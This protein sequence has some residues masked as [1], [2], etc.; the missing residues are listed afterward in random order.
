MAKGGVTAFIDKYNALSV[1]DQTVLQALSALYEP[2]A[3]VVVSSCL[4]GAGCRES[5]MRAFSPQIVSV[6]LAR[7]G[8]AGFAVESTVE[9]RG[10][11]VR[12]W[13]CRP[14]I[15][16]IAIR[17]AVRDG[18]F[19]PMAKAV[20]VETRGRDW[21]LEGSDDSHARRFRL[22]FH[23]GD[24]RSA[25]SELVAL[26]EEKPGEG[27]SLLASLVRLQADDSWRRT[28]KPALFA[29]VLAAALND[30]FNGA[31]DSEP[32]DSLAAEILAAGVDGAAA[33]QLTLA[34]VDCLVTRGRLRDA[35]RVAQQSSADEFRF[36]ALL[37]PALAEG[38]EDVPAIAESAAA[39]RRA[40]QSARDALPRGTAAVW[41]ALA[42]LVD[43]TPDAVESML[44]RLSGPS[45]REH[46]YAGAL[47]CLRHAFLFLAGQAF[48]A[49]NIPDQPPDAMPL[50]SLV[51]GL[52][53]L[54]IDPARLPALAEH[55]E[56]LEK[57]SRSAGYKWLAEQFK[58][59]GA[60]AAGDRVEDG[61]DDAA[62]WLPL[63]RL[64]QGDDEWRRGL[65]ALDDLAL[66]D[67]IEGSQP[68]KRLAWLV[69]AL[70]NPDNPYAPFEIQPIEQSMGKDGAWSKGRN[71]ALRRIFQHADDLSYV[72]DQDRMIFST[73]R[74][75]YTGQGFRFDSSAALPHL[76]GHPLV[77]RGDAG[78]ARLDVVAGEFEL[79][80]AEKDGGCEIGMEPSL[81]DFLARPDDAA[82]R[83]TSE[84]ELPDTAARLETP[85]RLRVLRLGARERRLARV[86]G[87]GLAIPSRGRSEAV[88][89]LSRLSG[90]IRLHSDIPELAGEGEQVEADP[91]P[92]FHVTPQNPGLK[93]EIWAHPLGDDGP[94]YRPGKGGRVL[95]ADLDGRTVRTT[96][97]IRRE[98]ELAEEALAACPSLSG[99][100]D[101]DLSWRLDDPEDALA[102]LAETE[103]LGDKAVL[104]WPKGGRF[105]VRR[106]KGLGGLS[107]RVNSSSEWFELDGTL[108]VDENLVLDMGRLM[109]SL[110]ASRGRFVEIGDGEY[111][112]LT[113][114]LRRQLG[115][116][117]AMGEFHD[118]K[119]RLHSLAGSVLEGLEEAG[120]EL[121]DDAEWRRTLE[122]RKKLA[123][124]IPEPPAG[125]TAE[126]RDY[127]LD[128]YRWMARLA[129]WGAGACLADDMGLGKT[130]QAL[131]MLVR[132]APLGP[133]LVVAPT[134]VCHNWIAETGRF[135]PGLR[136]FPFGDGDRAGRIASLG[137]GDVLI[138]SYSLLRQEDEL[139]SGVKWATAVLDEAQ[140][141]KNVSAKRSKAAMAL[142]A[143]FRLIT[144]GTPIENHLG[145]LWNLFRF[146]NPHLLG[147]WKKFQE[148]FAGPIE[149]LR[150]KEAGDRLRRIIRPFILRRTKAQVLDS[151]PPKTEI[152]LAVELGERERAFYES[153]RRNALERLEADPESALKKR[154]QILAEIMRL[155]RAC[156]SP[157]LIADGAGIP[158][159]KQEQFRTTLAEL[160][161]NKHKVLVF[162]QFVDHLAIIRRHLDKEGYSY[163]YL[164][165]ST[166]AKSRKK[167]VDD[168]QSGIGDVFLISLKA[169]GPG[170]NLTAADYVMHMDP[171]WNPAV[172]DQASDRAHRIGQDKPVTVYRLVAAGTIEEKIVQL[173]HDKR[174]LADNLLSGAD[175]AAHLD[176]EEIMRLLRDG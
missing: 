23:G 80:V 20:M 57:R 9:V 114:E 24:W 43:D 97:R 33:G 63:T 137:P 117:E 150:D 12:R 157:E 92:R 145:E 148:R 73:L 72:T 74:Y 19:L 130:I 126:L 160:V 113:N 171:W 84:D 55:F 36:A 45:A 83:S 115:D 139:L 4:N 53:M 14:E 6:R 138:T 93:V 170:L 176:I 128:G 165:G 3:A 82:D 96:R 46:E 175:Q 107:I 109:A 161:E 11:K 25:M 44:R 58:A 79:S 89:T 54:R 120:A 7:L 29:P 95:T 85:T 88:Q 149:R 158:S 172:E 153:L 67:T 125:F 124:F 123:D 106:F 77:Y 18:R 37:L 71:I 146:I 90:K 99:H 65:R 39:Q 147:S 16:E 131:A 35:N 66:D 1:A 142:D 173:H 100:A 91:R 28:A 133:A 169:G 98:K 143:G 13:R 140:A 152:T 31:N 87:D 8:K 111:L 144:T 68:R 105:R 15:G 94:A 164:D 174:D 21:K 118:G 10:Q 151:L 116:L 70:V 154:F 52:S 108:R 26:S 69:H 121:A 60:A 110:R 38:R 163:Q 102:F 81:S 27:G 162:S 17:H 5:P 135:A 86:V 48:A 103:D 119:F 129:E 141:I 122:R 30:V 56:L 168:F 155:R 51:H 59:L 2:A 112:A 42:A 41:Q 136:I 76:V 159:A 167:A 104:A 127:Q 49:R 134:S 40:R 32:L 22:A 75:D 47:L 61:G 156:C 166:P 34:L 64:F 78:G 101:G 50:T 132:R 62:R